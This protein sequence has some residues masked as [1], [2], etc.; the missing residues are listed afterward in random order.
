VSPIRERAEVER[1]DLR[2]VDDENR[3]FVVTSRNKNYGD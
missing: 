2:F 1:F 3:L